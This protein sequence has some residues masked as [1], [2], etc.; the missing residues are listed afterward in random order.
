MFFL[1]GQE[2]ARW[3]IGKD[4]TSR[5]EWKSEPQKCER[6]SCNIVRVVWLEGKLHVRSKEK[7]N[8]SKWCWKIIR[9]VNEAISQIAKSFNFI[10]MVPEATREFCTL[11]SLDGGQKLG[12]KQKKSTSTVFT[13]T[14]LCCGI[15]G[16]FCKDTKKTFFICYLIHLTI[17]CLEHIC[18]SLLRI[19]RRQTRQMLLSGSWAWKLAKSEMT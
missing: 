10:S 9:K 5:G 14:P 18:L 4:I 11:P 12:N 16:N 7:S 6:A 17:L 1:K 19:Q 8:S 3:G 2:F 13:S 15:N